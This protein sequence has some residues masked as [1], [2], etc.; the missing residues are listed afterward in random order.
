MSVARG[1][2]SIHAA[3]EGGDPEGTVNLKTKIISIHAAREGGDVTGYH[4]TNGVD[5]SIHAA[6][7]GGDAAIAVPV[8]GIADF[9]PRRP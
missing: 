9:N 1:A 3:R 6:R 2:I 8:L 5:I 4:Y 7:E